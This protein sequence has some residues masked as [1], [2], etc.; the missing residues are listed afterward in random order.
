MARLSLEVHVDGEFRAY[1]LDHDLP[2]KY[3]EVHLP[4]LS[5]ENE[6]GWYHVD[7]VQRKYRLLNQ[8]HKEKHYVPERHIIYVSSIE[9]KD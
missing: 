7:K 1:L 9:N 3:D 4:E 5:T 6:E 2:K 8:G